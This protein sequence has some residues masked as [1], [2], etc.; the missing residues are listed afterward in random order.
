MCYS[1]HDV[2][3]PFVVTEYIA[4]PC[5]GIGEVG[6]SGGWSQ[7]ATELTPCSSLQ[8]IFEETKYCTAVLLSQQQYR[9]T[10]GSFTI[11]IVV[12]GV[13]AFKYL[14][15]LSDFNEKDLNVCLI[16]ILE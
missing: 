4:N 13:L 11:L 8:E 12:F 10:Y 7:Q 2:Y 6:G 9:F 16:L 1:T 15:S 14:L 3:F 5:Q